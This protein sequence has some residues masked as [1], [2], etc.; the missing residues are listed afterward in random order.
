MGVV[1]TATKKLAQALSLD[2]KVKFTGMADWCC[3]FDETNIQITTNVKNLSILSSTKTSVVYDTG[4]QNN[5]AFTLEVLNTHLIPIQSDQYDEKIVVTK[6]KLIEIK[7]DNDKQKLKITGREYR[8][9][10]KEKGES[11]LERRI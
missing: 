10:A 9:F 7:T 1:V 6:E 2:D 4:L 8:T 11:Y 3:S 5:E